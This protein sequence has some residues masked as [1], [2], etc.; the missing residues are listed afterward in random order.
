MVS[1]GSV[2]S[3]RRVR[4]TRAEGHAEPTALR[5]LLK[6]FVIHDKEMVISLYTMTNRTYNQ[7]MQVIKIVCLGVAAAL[8]SSAAT[9]VARV[10]STQ[11]VN[12]DGIVG[13]ARNFVP[14]AVGNE[15][16]TDS[17]SAVVQFSD[18][19][20]VTLQ[21][22]SKL[23]IEG[24]PSG[25]V[26]RVVQGS[27]IYDMARTPSSRP[28]NGASES[29]VRISPGSAYRNPAAR[30]PGATAP[31]ARAFTGTFSPGGS[32]AGVGSSTGPQ[33]VSP[34]GVTINLTSVVNPSTG[35]TTFVVSSIQQTIMTPGGGTSVVTVTSGTLIGCTVGGI[36][37][38]T[39]T[40]TP[41]GSGTPLTPQQTATAVQNGLQQAINNGMANGTLPTGT[42]PPSPAPVTS[43]QF[44][45][46]GS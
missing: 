27:A 46:S 41:S 14:L 17:A 13:P 12:V 31:R 43:G 19:S 23:R 24:Q 15:V 9:P 28:G 39:F 29:S 38:G 36:T 44:S 26:A 21:P 30:Q 42:Q 32:A 11:P 16:T 4:H 2:S 7:A 1:I 45:P 33:I 40:F 25:P 6:T 22:H 20:V 35:A 8:V 37:S 5:R 34:N 18:G 10:I 3:V